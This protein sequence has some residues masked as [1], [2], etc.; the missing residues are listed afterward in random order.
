M[1]IILCIIG[2]WAL[3]ACIFG[4]IEKIIL[5]IEKDSR[6]KGVFEP[7]IK[8]NRIPVSLV[9]VLRKDNKNGQ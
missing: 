3:L 8:K 6:L 7:Y 4:L 2:A 5:L 9:N 1:I